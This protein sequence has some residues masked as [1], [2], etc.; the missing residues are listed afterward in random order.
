MTAGCQ[1]REGDLPLTTATPL[2]ALSLSHGAATLI[3]D[4]VLGGSIR[5]FQVGQHQVFRRTPPGAVDITE[6]A[7]FP[8]I[9]IVNRIPDGVFEF[10]DHHVDLEGNFLGLPD[11]IHGH[12]WRAPWR[13][14]ATTANKAM[15]AFDY[16]PGLWPWRYRGV[17]VF[18]LRERGL[19][20]SLKVTNLSD[21]RMPAALGFHPYF[22]T[23]SQTKLKFN[24]S[25]HWVNNALGHALRRMPGAF[26]QDFRN[27][28]SLLDEVMTDATHYEWDGRAALTEAGRPTVIITASEACKNLHV[29]FPPNGTY[30]AIEPTSGRSN[31]FNV[32]PVEYEVLDPGASFEIWM[33]VSVAQEPD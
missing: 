17:Q 12:G 22:P 3:L 23:T 24:F 30:A 14:E 9:P 8:L 11:F 6:T 29:F 7:S 10:D 18:E 13:I 15:L 19:R 26:R 33:D 28:A 20:H 16:S 21:K 1:N 32:G 27:G 31:P 2:S 25:G 4:P 5:S